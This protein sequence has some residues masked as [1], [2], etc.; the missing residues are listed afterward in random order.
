MGLGRKDVEVI[1]FP[2]SA[3]SYSPATSFDISQLSLDSFQAPECV[4][5]PLDTADR[6]RL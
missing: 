1:E 2:L 6:S 5:V 3:S 4:F